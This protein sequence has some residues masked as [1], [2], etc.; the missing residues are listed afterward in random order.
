MPFLR[1]LTHC[2]YFTTDGQKRFPVQ[3]PVLLELTHPVDFGPKI[4]PICLPFFDTFNLAGISGSSIGYG[5]K[6]TLKDKNTNHPFTLTNIRE[7]PAPQC[8]ERLGGQVV[9]ETMMCTVSGHNR[10]MCYVSS[11]CKIALITSQIFR[12]YYTL[13][14]NN[15]VKFSLSVWK[16]IVVDYVASDPHLFIYHHIDL[17][18]SFPGQRDEGGPLMVY[19][20]REAGYDSYLTTYAVLSVPGCRKRTKTPFRSSFRRT[21]RAADRDKEEPGTTYTAEPPPGDKQRKNKTSVS[22]DDE[23]LRPEKTQSHKKGKGGN[24]NK[25]KNKNKKKKKKKKS[26]PQP[27]KYNKN[28]TTNVNVDV[29]IKMNSYVNWILKVVFYERDYLICQRPLDVSSAQE[30]GAAAVQRC[31]P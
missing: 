31:K 1:Y 23:S 11:F 21:R 14:L 30:G 17:L 27:K 18:S 9:D 15:K 4:S 10:G 7:L 6:N 2:K 25:N 16:V 26:V 5:F 8:Q 28:Q 12:I 20:T 3:C 22:D 19:R 13:S 29:W 24:K